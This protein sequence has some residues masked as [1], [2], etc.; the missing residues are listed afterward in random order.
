VYPT[1][2]AD[3][4]GIEKL[5]ADERLY[6]RMKTAGSVLVGTV[7]DVTLLPNGPPSSEH[8][9]LWAEAT[10]TADCALRGAD[11]QVAHAV[12]ATSDDVAWYQSPKL[13]VGQKGVFLLQPKPTPPGLW[14]IPDDIPYMITDPLDAHPLDDRAHIA[15]LVLCPPYH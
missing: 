1:I 12:F 11:P 14:E 4:P 6:E 8:D 3:V 2:E 5:L 15:T 10:I 7:T 9:P 13:T